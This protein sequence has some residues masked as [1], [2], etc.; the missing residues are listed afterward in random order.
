MEVTYQVN[1][2]SLR[3]R[4]KKKCRFGPYKR[5]K[6]ATWHQTTHANEHL[7]PSSIPDTRDYQVPLP[8]IPRT[9]LQEQEA[10]PTSPQ[11]PYRVTFTLPA[12]RRRTPFDRYFATA[13]KAPQPPA[14][15]F[16][17]RRLGITQEELDARVTREV[18]E[19]LQEF[20]AER[21]LERIT[22][23]SSTEAPRI[24]TK[25]DCLTFCRATGVPPPGALWG[26]YRWAADLG[27]T[28]FNFN[29]END[30]YSVLDAYDCSLPPSYDPTRSQA[31]NLR[32]R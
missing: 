30:D 16:A 4:P 28:R 21:A 6:T 14:N 29:F 12:P 31:D 1:D 18:D 23:N 10:E 20:R 15:R 8:E 27:S 2:K 26:V 25:E 11:G 9:D 7:P 5:H 13:P 24:L 32:L 3:S 22:A 19:A 17:L